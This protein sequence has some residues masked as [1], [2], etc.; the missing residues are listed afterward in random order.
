MAHRRTI[1]NFTISD[2]PITA[3]LLVEFAAGDYYF[4]SDILM[5]PTRSRIP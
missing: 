1:S 5:G 4:M 2:A 3:V